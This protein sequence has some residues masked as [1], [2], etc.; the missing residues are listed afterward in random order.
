VTEVT[1]KQDPV[2]ELRVQAEQ[3]NDLT[4]NDSDEC[5]SCTTTTTATS[6]SPKPD[7]RHNRIP[8]LEG[9]LRY[10]GGGLG[11]PA[12][13]FAEIDPDSDSGNKI[14]SFEPK[15]KPSLSARKYS[16]ANP[17]NYT[18]SAKKNQTAN[19]TPHFSRILV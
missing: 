19:N 2:V 12:I 9:D 7:V 14:T 6:S 1:K 18:L 15:G 16:T 3:G 4:I 8:E 17:V 11:E 10:L 5:C 13:S